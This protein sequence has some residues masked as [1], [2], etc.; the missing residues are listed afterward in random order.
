MVFR[1]VLDQ[2]NSPVALELTGEQNVPK[3][4]LIVHD[5]EYQPSDSVLTL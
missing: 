2:T 1:T 5:M 3:N 4:Q